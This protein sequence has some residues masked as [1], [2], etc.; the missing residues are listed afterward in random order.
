MGQCVFAANVYTNFTCFNGRDPPPFRSIHVRLWHLGL[1]EVDLALCVLGEEVDRFGAARA[2]AGCPVPRAVDA[3]DIVCHCQ[4]DILLF[5]EVGDHLVE[6]SDLVL[7]LG[8]VEPV[9]LCCERV[10]VVGHVV[11]FC[12][13]AVLRPVPAPVPP[14][15]LW[16]IISRGSRIN[17]TSWAGCGPLGAHNPGASDGM[18]FVP[19]TKKRRLQFPS[20]SETDSDGTLTEAA[21]LASRGP[22]AVAWDSDSEGFP[23]RRG[24]NAGG[25]SGSPDGSESGSGSGSESESES[26]S[27]GSGSIPEAC[28][29]C[30]EPVCG[31]CF[32]AEDRC[33]CSCGSSPDSDLRVEVIETR[34]CRLCIRNVDSESESDSDSDFDSG[35]L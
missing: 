6:G 35:G 13:S 21:V 16:S 22:S 34:H 29:C 25:R 14:V 24:L 1:V 15:A 7:H 19:V 23:A 11:R 32:C 2:E 10:D 20:D 9:C 8:G 3:V 4:C 31:H 28:D 33:A 5:L 30:G 26:E 27:D 17:R 12:G 18:D